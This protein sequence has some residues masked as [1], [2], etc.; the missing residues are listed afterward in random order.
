[1]SNRFLSLDDLTSLPAPS[2]MV[3]DMFEVNSLV[4]VIGPPGNYK[5]FLAIDWSLSMALG[6]SWNGRKTTPAK[7]LYCLGEGKSNL[8]KRFNAWIIHHRLSLE[9]KI[10]LNST[11]RVDFE[12]PQ[13]ASKASVDNMLAQLQAEK[14]QPDVIVVDTFARS[15]VGLDENSQKDTGLWI[16]SAD[17]LRK[18][19]YTVI[20]VH[21]T[22]KN[23][24][25]GLKYRGSS[26]IL[27]AMDTSFTLCKDRDN[28]MLSKLE[29]T[30]QKDHD[31][32]D[33]IYFTRVIVPS[34]DKDHDGSMVLVPTLKMDSEFTPEGQ[35]AEEKIRKL[36][37]SLIADNSFASDRDRAKELA[38][39][40]GLTEAA[41]QSKISRTVRHSRYI[42][43]GVPQ[44]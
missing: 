10:K 9:E 39:Q 18:L 1:L 25:F 33:P 26:A 15:F 41:A 16:E 7:V 14:F 6:R 44:G 40:T 17:R 22:A 30:K 23:T 5:S 43:A 8:L 32:G 4:M 37:M 28:K 3:E 21:H 27:G 24:E 20:F 38:K 31:E 2:W 34:A 19:G 13:L 36:M 42:E 12:M 11:L 35:T 29:C